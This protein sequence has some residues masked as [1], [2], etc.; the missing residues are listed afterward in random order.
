[1]ALILFFVLGWFVQAASLAGQTPG[2]ASGGP[3]LE[4]PEWSHQVGRVPADGPPLVHTFVLRNAGEAKLRI[5]RIEKICDCVSF[6][7]GSMELAPGESTRLEVVI[8]VAGKRGRFRDGVQ[9]FSNSV[10][11][12]EAVFAM[13]GYAFGRLDIRPERL[14]FGE[15]PH[16]FFERK[17]FWIDIE[18]NDPAIAGVERL[19]ASSP[20]V[21]ARLQEEDENRFRV[22]IRLNPA[23]G[24]ETDLRESVTVFFAGEKPTR[25]EI[26]ITA[27]APGAREVTPR[28][29][30]LEEIL[31]QS[32]P[33]RTVYLVH[34]KPF[35]VL[36]AEVPPFVN[37]R[38]TPLERPRQG[39]TIH[40][41]K[42]TLEI[43]PAKV[44][45]APARTVLRF[46][47]DLAEAPDAIVILTPS[48]Y[49]PPSP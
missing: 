31:A 18:I 13:E 37:W 21:S 22:R 24:V 25:V 1:M 48:R 46:H 36:Q 15:Q 41:Q 2:A 43:D 11:A 40:V 19:T 14:D 39:K 30:Y 3:L 42:L 6:Q 29:I 35:Q 20:V 17:E 23:P 33:A 47:T 8:G 26:P 16:E 28:Q 34:P 38:A 9:I 4:A 27:L 49:A 32:P 45:T 10:Q 7:I 44:P 12:P 5:E